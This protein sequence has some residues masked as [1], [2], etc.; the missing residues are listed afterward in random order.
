LND[1]SVGLRVLFVSVS[2]EIIIFSLPPV[3]IVLV[4]LLAVFFDPINVIR[5]IFII[6]IIIVVVVV[7]L[8]LVAIVVIVV[9]A[10]N[11]LFVISIPTATL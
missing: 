4:T 5:L 6:I 9:I 3:S 11:F 2:C 8:V 7:V 1:G 10:V